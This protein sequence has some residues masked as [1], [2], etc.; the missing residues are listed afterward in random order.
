MPERVRATN[1]ALQRKGDI[2]LDM[3]AEVALAAGFVLAR[4][5]GSHQSYKKAGF[6]PVVT[7]PT[8][9]M[10]RGTALKLLKLIEQSLKEGQ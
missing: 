3:V 9:K 6:P 7:I 10:G 1:A 2:A 5:K 8:K 4:K